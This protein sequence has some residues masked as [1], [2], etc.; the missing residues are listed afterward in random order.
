MPSG[1]LN[2]KKVAVVIG[3]GSVK[4]A[5]AIGLQ[6]VLQREGIEIDL[7]VGCSGGS[8]YATAMALGYDPDTV[9]DMT[10][11]LWTREATQD[12]NRRAMLAALLP[13]LFGFSE[14]FGLRDD[15]RV[16][17][18]LRQVLGERT[19]A[20]AHIPLHIAATDFHTGEQVDLAHGQLVDAIRAS[21]AIPFVFEPWPVDDRLLLD[22]VLSDPLPV[23]IA[24]KAGA[25]VILAM[26]F[27][28]PYQSRVTTPVR[29]AFQISSI[30]TNNLLRSNYAFH[31]LAH[32]SEIIAI[33]PEFQQ[34]I[35]L[36]DV[37]KI[38][39]IIEEGERAA[40]Q[41]LPYLR[42]LLLAA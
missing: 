22:G 24:I 16:L 15:R 5:A 36:F 39:Y 32:H 21:I 30:M 2:Q 34:R 40:E 28:S 27:D 7:L 29:F 20:D 31:G 9:A 6:R 42:R 38:P 10:R 37:D 41:Q 18:R 1:S 14:R 12:S 23:G 11:R 19:F 4:C 35:R 8:L 17:A 13:R 3:S 33:V 26:G 25:N